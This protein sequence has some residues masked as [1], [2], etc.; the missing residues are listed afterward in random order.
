MQ[1]VI[2]VLPT[3]EVKLARPRLEQ[4]MSV[5]S[6]LFFTQGFEA[7]SLRQLA[8][9]AGISPGTMY[10]YI[11]SKQA[12]LYDLMDETLSLLLNQSTQ[13]LRNRNIAKDELG[14]VLNVFAKLAV[15]DRANLALAL[16]HAP[17]L[18]DVQR[19]R[20]DI[21]IHQYAELLQG[22]IRK[23]PL[24][25]D[26]K[27]ECLRRLVRGVLTLLRT[28]IEDNLQLEKGEVYD[29]YSSLVDT[30]LD[31]C[32]PCRTPVAKKLICEKH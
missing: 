1:T 29:M 4:I 17:Q 8:K 15:T 22:L 26:I 20:I 30:W 11:E 21:K 23:K 24:F 6:Q 28:C 19:A 18:T 14:I 32:P 13:A 5:A 31:S 2:S 7:V 12:L 10:N 16:R 27:P 3:P 9:G 25:Q